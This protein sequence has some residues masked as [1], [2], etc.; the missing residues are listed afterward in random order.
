M[1][2]ILKLSAKLWSLSKPHLKMNSN[3][4]TK[5]SLFLRVPESKSVFQF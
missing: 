5:V 4:E 1:H 2:S 3:K